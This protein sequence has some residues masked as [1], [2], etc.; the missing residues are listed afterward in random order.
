[1]IALTVTGLKAHWNLIVHEMFPR[2]LMIEAYLQLRAA[3][4]YFKNTG[5]ALINRVTLVFFL[6]NWL[7]CSAQSDRIIVDNIPCA[8]TFLRLVGNSPVELSHFK[9]SVAIRNNI[10][11]CES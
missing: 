3:I 4:N 2:H 8:R 5:R 10:L 1:M 9:K 11:I 7:L 6:K